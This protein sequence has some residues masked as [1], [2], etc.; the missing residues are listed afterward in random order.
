MQVLK[1]AKCI[2]YTVASEKCIIHDRDVLIDNI[3]LFCWEKRGFPGVEGESLYI[4]YTLRLSSRRYRCLGDGELLWA[5]W[6]VLF[7]LS[8]WI[9]RQLPNS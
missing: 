3:F 1:L 9:L 6:E 2:Q 8:V 5:F 7:R 4:I